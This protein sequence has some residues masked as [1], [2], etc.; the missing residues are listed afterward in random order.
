MLLLVS[1]GL[2]L[3][4]LANLNAL[5]PGFNKRGLLL[6]AIE[7]PVQRYPAPENVEVLHQVEQKVASLPGVQSVTLSKEAL[8]AQSRSESDFLP[9]GRLPFL[10][11]TSTFLSTP[12]D[13]VFSQRWVYPFCMDGPLIPETRQILPALPSSMRH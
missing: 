10:D 7:P 12:S 11:E 3:R 9:D 6:F 8:L 13:K 1:A 2:F 5:D 4:T